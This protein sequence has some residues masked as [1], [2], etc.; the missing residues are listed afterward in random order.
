MSSQTADQS[1]PFVPIDIASL[2]VCQRGLTPVL[3][4]ISGLRMRDKPVQF[5]R[6]STWKI[7]ILLRSSMKQKG[8]LAKAMYSLELHSIFT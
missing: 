6:L 8:V 4:E 7:R 2:T 5:N 1:D 3:G